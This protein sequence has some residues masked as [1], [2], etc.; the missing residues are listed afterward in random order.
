EVVI[1]SQKIINVQLL[2]NQDVLNEVVVIGYGTSRKKDLTGS[3]TAIDSKAIAVQ[4]NSTVS[5]ALEGMVAGLQIAAI[6]GQPGIDTGIRLRGAGSTSQNS[7]NALIVI[8][9]VPAEH[10]NALSSINPKDIE[11][12]SVLKDAASTAVYGSRG[13]NGVV[14]VTT[15]KGVSGKTRISFEGKWGVNYAGALKFDKIT[16]AKDI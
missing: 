9:G 5:R 16:D 10:D 2:E 13:A 3:M 15:K 6:D 7:S 1:G 8:D 14:L 12:I 4:S 11:S